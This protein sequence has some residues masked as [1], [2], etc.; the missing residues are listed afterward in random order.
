MRRARLGHASVPGEPTRPRIPRPRLH[1][2]ARAPVRGLLATGGPPHVPRLVVAVVVDAINRMRWA[3]ALSDVAKKRTKVIHPLGGHADPTTAIFLV[4]SRPL[5]KAPSLDGFPRP[6]LLGASPTVP[7]PSASA[8]GSS[9]RAQLATAHVY[10]L[11]ALAC[12]PEPN[13]SLAMGVS[14]LYDTESTV[15]RAG[16]VRSGYGAAARPHVAT[17]QSTSPDHA[18]SAAVTVAGVGARPVR[19]SGELAGDEHVEPLPRVINARAS[20]SSAACWLSRHVEIIAPSRRRV[21]S[22]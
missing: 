16:F 6:V 1:R 10:D 11:A 13:P 14:A 2:A 18:R 7:P 8:T 21:S 19:E 4:A 9:S 12:A 5:V 22:R 20:S 15:Y 17:R 3:R